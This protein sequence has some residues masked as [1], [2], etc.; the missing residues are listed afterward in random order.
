[1]SIEIHVGDIP[2]QEPSSIL[3][4]RKFNS[5]ALDVI[6]CFLGKKLGLYIPVL[7]LVQRDEMALETRWDTVTKAL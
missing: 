6:K 4:R 7:A 3:Q 1:M 2:H 5:Q